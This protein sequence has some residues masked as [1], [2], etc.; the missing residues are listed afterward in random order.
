MLT[1]VF[2]HKNPDTDAVTS[3]I[4]MAYL[5]KQL[6]VDAQSF[7]LGDIRKEAKFVLDYF[8]V[9]K[10]DFLANV[11][12]QVS[13]LKIE[14][15]EGIHPNSSILDAF[16][17]IEEKKLQSLPVI[18]SDNKLVGIITMQDIVKGILEKDLRNLHTSLDNICRSLEGE[19]LYKA[20][21]EVNG[22]LYTLAYELESVKGLL[23]K[24]DIVI[25]GDRYD[26]IDHLL[27]TGI[28]LI[29]LTG[30][31]SLPDSYI[32]KAKKN[33]VSVIA[34]GV[35]T[36]EASLLINRCNYLESIASNE[37]IIKFNTGDLVEDIK[38]TM[39]N[40]SFRNFPVVDNENH[41]LGFIGRR[42]LVNPSR[43]KVIMTDHNEFAQ[44]VDG[45][46]EAEILEIVDHHKI[47]GIETSA[48]INFRNM[49][50]GCT[51]TIL[52]LMYKENRIEIPK[53]IAGLMI[54]GIISD[55][56]LFRSP[57]TTAIDKQVVTEL[58]EILK[59]DLEKYAMEMFKTGTSLEGYSIEEIVH[60]DFKEFTLEGKKVAIGQVFTLDV[61]SVFKKKNDF[62]NYLQQTTYDIALLAITDIVKEGSYLLYKASNEVID[63]AFSVKAEQGVWVNGLVSR[64]KQLVPNLTT[65]IGSTK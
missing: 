28:Q 40:S 38:E 35:D 11:K 45:I 62:I 27:E 9:E 42:H 61:D 39:L 3:A 47:G 54:S 13:D 50:V 1:Y 33:N 52:Y 4:C 59:L 65:G 31:K 23:T 2:G 49:T 29:I 32:A 24:N 14:K 36:Y 22:K 41:F 63:S 53:D 25:V 6:G 60:M 57:T 30:K 55:T 21:E 56:L 19:I 17:K 46:E 34:V 15:T 12:P 26:V 37:D 7:L 43:K 44:S 5:K 10:P 8:K 18:T 58:N 64:K 20:T 51:C 16:K 48:P